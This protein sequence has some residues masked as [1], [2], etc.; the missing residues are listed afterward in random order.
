MGGQYDIAYA[1]RLIET[2][3][4]PLE[5]GNAFTGQFAGNGQ[6]QVF[7]FTL[8]AGQPMRISLQNAG[9]NN[10]AELYAGFALPP[11][12]G[13][14]TQA[15][16]DGSGVN[17]ELLLDNAYAGTW[18]ALVYGDTIATPGTYTLT[19]QA[20]DVF[21]TRL[22][23]EQ[24]GSGGTAIVEIQGAGFSP[25]AQVAL[26][27]NGIALPAGRVTWVSS[28]RLVADFDLS[29]FKPNTYQIVVRQGGTTAS[30]PFAV[31]GATAR[32]LKRAWSRPTASDS[33]TSTRCMSID[34]NVGRPSRWSHHFLSFTEKVL[35]DQCCPWM[36]LSSLGTFGRPANPPAPPKP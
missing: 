30:L 2:V 24:C 15:S 3:Q 17:R 28:A 21:L 31:T 20:A 29:Q 14:Y 13:I 9:T 27:G 22:S 11:T 6:A 4:T 25:A 8:P 16:S 18:Y 23:P 36:R 34:S 35:L 33:T 10:R 12:R 32:S 1:C 7:K 26:E 19:V 5:L